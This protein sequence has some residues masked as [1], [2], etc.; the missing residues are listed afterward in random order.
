MT[1]IVKKEIAQT[2]LL[3]LFS[4]GLRINLALHKLE[5]RFSERKDAIRS[6]DAVSLFIYLL[7]DFFFSVMVNTVC[8]E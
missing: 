3:H 4:Q 2:H 8:V 6:G 5:Q 7:S 1:S